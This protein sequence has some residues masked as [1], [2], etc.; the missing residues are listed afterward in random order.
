MKRFISLML[1]SLTLTAH[2]QSVDNYVA[3]YCVRY[4]RQHLFLQ[5]DSDLNVV[6]YDL[7]W[8]DIINFNDVMPLKRYIS[9]LLLGVPTSSVDSV[10]MV[11]NGRMGDPVTKQFKEIPDDRRFC[12]ADFKAQIL[13]YVPNRFIAYRIS[14]SVK[15]ESLSGQAKYNAERY[16]LYDINNQK[17]L[18]P[19]DI[20]SPAVV[21]RYEPQVFYNQL[22]A[23]LGDYFDDMVKCDI[24]GVWIDEQNICFHVVAVTSDQ[25]INYDIKMPYQ[26]YSY[27]L[28]RK[29]RRVMEKKPKLISPSLDLTRQTWHGDTIYNKVES[30]P[31]FPGGGE[32]MQQYLSH[33]AKP[34]FA[35][36]SVMKVM[37]SYVVDRDGRVGDVCV[38]GPVSP[39]LDRHAA[40]VVRGMPRFTPG[41]QNGRPLCV[42]LYL[43]MVYRP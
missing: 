32:G 7:E 1:L 26:N 13:S 12:Y 2:A 30:M 14:A 23:P 9:K 5:K 39:E 4:E 16:V 34:E 31:V 15:P 37:M 21:N 8:P 40:S 38:V 35:Q 17:I 22:F 18:E 33:V 11:I 28:D 36:S 41:R 20:L 43:P 6:D 3:N 42:R 10:V 29:V 19:D 25:I 27:V 24:T